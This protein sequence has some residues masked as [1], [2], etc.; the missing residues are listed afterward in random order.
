MTTGTKLGASLA[1]ALAVIAALGLGSYV[2]TEQL[3]ETNRL[4][5]RTHQVIEKLNAFS[6]ALKDAEAD[7]R[8]YVLNGGEDCLASYAAA[9]GV[10]RG[11]LEGLGGLV[12]GGT[13]QTEALERVKALATERLASLDATI[14]LRRASGMD[15]ALHAIQSGK[16]KRLMDD[17]NAV[18]AEMMHHA[19]R[20]LDEQNSLS[21]A[22]AS[23]TIAMVAVGTP[24]SLLVL[25][26]FAM[27]VTGRAGNARYRA[28]PG[29]SPDRAGRIALQYSF[30]AVATVV[31]IALRLWLERHFGPLPTFVTVYPAV[32]LVA[33]VAGGGPGVFATIL[34]ALLSAYYYLP[35]EGFRID[36]TNDIL[37]LTI[38]TGT[39][40]MLSVLLG[41]LRRMQWAE[42]VSAAQEDELDLLNMGTV[43]ALDPD[44]RIVR[45][46]EGCRR[47]Y[48]Y[49]AK[50]AVGR[51]TQELFQAP[52]DD[53]LIEARRAL[54]EHGYWQG[55]RVR[56]AKDGRELAIA[57]L[58]AMR[59]D[60]KGRPHSIMEI[61]ADITDRRRAEEALR[62][63]EARYATTL[64]SIGD[65]VIAT[66]LESN[67]TFMNPEAERLTG[68]L[69]QEAMGRPIAQFFRII[70]EYTRAEVESPVDRVLREG[71]I[72]GL[73]NHTLLI[74]KDG[75]EIPI[76]DSG[77]PIKDTVGGTT[78]VVLVFRDITE[79][80]QAEDAVRESE[81]RLHFALS[82]SQTGAWDLDLVDHTAFRT[83]EHDRVFGYEAL[84]SQWTYEMFLNHVLP[85][86]RAEVDR[87]F[88]TAIQDK[89]NWDFEC[90]I[91][92]TDGEQRWIWA[93]GRHDQDAHGRHRR[94]TGIVQDITARKQAEQVLRESE[95]R[96]EF[97]AQ[98]LRNASQ[99][100]A[101]GYP[102]G[103]LNMANPAFERLT[104]YDA[105]ELRSIDWATTL[106]PP[107]WATMES[108]ELADLNR[109]GQPVRYQKEYVR[110]D[111]TRVPIELL[112]HI[113]RDSEG[114]PDYYYSFLTDI[115]DRKRMEEALQRARDELELRV[116]ERTAE[117]VQ[118]N[119]QLERKNEE[120][121]RTL[122][123]LRTSEQRLA[124][125]QRIARRG[126]WDWNIRTDEL[127]WSDEMFRIF[128]HA[129]QA[130]PVNY[131][132]FLELV[133]TD[134]RGHV[135]GSMDRALSGEAD[136]V[137][138]YRIVLPDGGERVLKAQ[139]EITRDDGGEPVRMFGTAMDVTEQVRAEEESRLRQQQL[140]QADKM[141]SLGILTSGVA[142][143]INNPNHSILSNVTALADV[144]RD[145]RPILDRFYGDFGDFVLGGFEYSECRDKMPG[146]FANALTSSKRIELIVNELRDFARSSPIERMA[147]TDVNAVVHSAGILM[148]S[149]V[150]KHT[151][152]YAVEL[153]PDL[154]TV[155][156]NFQRIEQILVN[157]IQ[158]ACQSL[159]DRDRAVTVRTRHDKPSSRVIIE[160]VD[161]GAGIAAES[162]KQMGT[163][164]YTTKLDTKGTGLGLWISTNIAHEHGGSLTFTSKPGEGTRA[165]LSLPADA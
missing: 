1:V 137:L 60:K 96:N 5:I 143:E 99:P 75:S 147:P 8:D 38:F 105:E 139:G 154:P 106:T 142:H 2:S 32:L 70:N 63:S 160:V 68:W 54:H 159:P 89:G 119:R 45:W 134:D 33:S 158:N 46:S 107:E 23:H 17:I 98:L 94:M 132:R 80:K 64:A 50:E 71:I 73:A 91:L 114:R 118:E 127:A 90:R 18:T 140:V 104:G 44:H 109:T 116:A 120:N 58:W 79:R 117:L 37:A 81:E 153:A 148:S 126:N 100:F 6:A 72:V 25:A 14:A 20:L 42:A 66:D 129:P 52:L 62:E 57:V 161:E 144:W 141:V 7:Q 30:A 121:A 150:K 87:K 35:P 39:N 95:R 12:G 74:R 51:I 130:F 84:C 59:R 152:R 112:V 88:Q 24:I 135:R 9:C 26:V 157:L 110:K 67:I 21:K 113:V 149:M 31:G 78:G 102:D 77:A 124:E 34:A 69:L 92:R 19:D 133:H 27:V 83:I 162:I 41:Q 4:V 136:Y 125:A 138:Q 65:A 131:A 103:R 76:D 108:K 22:R 28:R 146:M 123:A 163:P 11:E 16:G 122:D 86:D 164:F 145:V 55:E 15:A 115:S 128:G 47:L 93:C 111:G 29:L 36:A 156:G 56:R 3:L 97:L 48:G 13:V 101:V 40:L 10:V 53:A 82:V 165:I 85:E 151:D 49:D 61:S 43:L 155:T